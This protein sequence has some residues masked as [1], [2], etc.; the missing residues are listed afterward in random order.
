M[1]V[2][3]IIQNYGTFGVACVIM[4]QLMSLQARLA[5]MENRILTLERTIRYDR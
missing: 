2:L 1:E 4:F 5:V 3:N